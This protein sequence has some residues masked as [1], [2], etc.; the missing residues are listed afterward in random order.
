MDDYLF[1][2]ALTLVLIFAGLRMWWIYRRGAGQLFWRTPQA[3]QLYVA[4]AMML[5]AFVVAIFLTTEY[6]L[7]LAAIPATY[8]LLSFTAVKVNE[9]GIMANAMM[10]R[11]Q[12]IVRLHHNEKGGYIKVTTRHPW[13]WI[14]L[15]VPPEKF[16]E[17]RKMLAAKGLGLSDRPQPEETFA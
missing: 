17:F 8:F 10:A 12:D 6:R 4:A 7:L 16:H 13:Q 1:W 3:P 14:K 11:W 9:S 2:S 15:R 5:S